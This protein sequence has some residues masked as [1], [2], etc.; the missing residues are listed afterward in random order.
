MSGWHLSLTM[1]T[2]QNVLTVFP[3]VLCALGLS[4]EKVLGPTPAPELS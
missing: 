1:A 4:L 3:T 2:E